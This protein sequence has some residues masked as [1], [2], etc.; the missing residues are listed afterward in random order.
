MK[1]TSMRSEFFLRKRE[2]SVKKRLAM[3][4]LFSSM[5]PETSIRQNITAWVVGRVMQARFR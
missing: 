5:E 3:F 4:F 1:T 2:R